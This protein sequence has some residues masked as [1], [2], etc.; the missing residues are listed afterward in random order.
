MRLGRGRRGD[1]LAGCLGTDLWHRVESNGSLES[2]G[3]EDPQW[4]GA[5]SGRGGVRAWGW[6]GLG[7]ALARLGNVS[8][9]G[10]A[11]R[12]GLQDLPRAKAHITGRG[13]ERRGRKESRFFRAWAGQGL[14]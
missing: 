5:R 1:I 4:G 7:Q 10:I 8:L 11:S 6:R 14:E 13:L 2:C 3:N 9:L 12:G